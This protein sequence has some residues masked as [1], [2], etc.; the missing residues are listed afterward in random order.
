MGY[1]IKMDRQ[2]IKQPIVIMYSL[3]WSQ[4]NFV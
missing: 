2:H 4:S 3:I 1:V